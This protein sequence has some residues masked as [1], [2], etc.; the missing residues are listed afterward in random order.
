MVLAE[1][2]HLAPSFDGG[3]VLDARFRC[4]SVRGSGTCSIQ[5]ASVGVA[6]LLALLTALPPSLAWSQWGGDAAS[7]GSIEVGPAWSDVAFEVKLPGS[8]L[9]TAILRDREAFFS[10]NESNGVWSVN[11]DTGA[12][13]EVPGAPEVGQFWLLGDFILRRPFG[14]ASVDALDLKTGALLWTSPG[15]DIGSDQVQV[16]YTIWQSATDGAVILLPYVAQGR[17]PVPTIPG[18]PAVPSA[19]R[20]TIGGMIAVDAATGRVLW[21]APDPAH[22]ANLTGRLSPVSTMGQGIALLYARVETG[23]TTEAG[24]AHPL[25][26]Y[27][28][29]AFDAVTGNLL[30]EREDAMDASVTVA[31]N[32]LVPGLSGSNGGVPVIT[33][34]FV[35]IRTD[36]FI[37]INPKTGAS[38]WESSAGLTDPNP[39]RGMRAAGWGHGALLATTGQTL[40][41]L[42][43]LTGEPLW[44]R[45][46]PGRFYSPESI[47]ISSTHAYVPYLVTKPNEHVTRAF[48]AV[49]LQT[50]AVVWSHEKQEPSGL[51]NGLRAPWIFGGGLAARGGEDGTITVIGRSAASMTP[52]ALKSEQFPAVGEDITVDLSGARAGAFGAPTRYRA[53]WG[54]GNVTEWQASPEFKH[55]YATPTPTVARFT[56]GNDA[57]QT[58]TTT[59]TFRVGES[60]P[61]ILSQAFAPDNQDRTFFIIGAAVSA[62]GALFGFLAVRRKRGRLQREIKAVDKLVHD[63]RENANAT[64]LAMRERRVRARALL[65]DGKLDDTQANLLEKHIDDVSRRVRLQEV[66][67]DLD[68]LPQGIARRLREALQDG[69]ISTLERDYLTRLVDDDRILT[70]QQKASVHELVDA[71]WRGDAGQTAR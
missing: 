5:P 66:D 13:T 40:Y 52:P 14:V 37:A 63:L 42:D 57:N 17:A 45:T 19:S 36:R 35:F 32:S 24:F 59:V 25:R 7:T 46:T 54:D 9:G 15:P 27:R 61:N 62:G 53:D 47:A 22:R 12:I 4:L 67:H 41:R 1:S 69:R 33:D 70:P 43:P 60:E 11:L 58:A 10:T 65:V 30:W 2:C 6:M 3:N 21:D 18:A 39:V 64:D 51:T 68:F 8:V 50:G 16:S 23:A 31:E 29:L 44:Q 56:V 71:W 48:E 26:K 28:L 38:I 49:D 34:N 55:A 20:P